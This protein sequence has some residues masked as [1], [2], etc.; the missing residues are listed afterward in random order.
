LRFGIDNIIIL[1]LR[2]GLTIVPYIIKGDLIIVWIDNNIIIRDQ[3]KPLYKT[4]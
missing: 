1:T 4:L 3:S 2:N